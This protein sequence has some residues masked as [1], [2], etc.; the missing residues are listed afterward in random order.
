MNG[1]LVLENGSEYKGLSFG[2]EKYIS[3]EVVFSTNM[4]GYIESFTDPSFCDQI[5]C[6]TYPLIGNYGVP[7]ADVDNNN[8]LINMESANIWIKAL[9]VA[10]YSK[11][12]SHYNAKKSLSEWLIENKIPALTNIDTRRLTKELRLNG[13]LKG[14][15]IFENNEQHDQND[16]VDINKSNLVKKVTCKNLYT[17]GEGILHIAVLDCGIKL[18]ILRNLISEGFKITVLPYDY[19][20]ISENGYDGIFISNGPGDP[21]MCDITINN[22]RK[23]INSDN[24]KPVFGICLGNQLLAHAAGAKTYKMKY[25]NR[26]YNQPV[27]ML[28]TKT[29][30]ITSQNH[31]FAVDKDSLPEDWEELCINKNDN[32]N[33]GIRHKTK[34]FKSVQ[35]HPEARGGPFDTSYMF[36]EFYNTCLDHKYGIVQKN[37]VLL[38]GSGGLSIG[39]AGEFDYSGSQAIKSFKKNGLSVILVNP[40]IASIQTS[41]GL[42]DEVYYVP[43]QLEFITDIIIKERPQYISLS[44]G[45]QT[46]LN[47][48]IELFHS[49]ILYKY[50]V[51]VLGT[52]VDNILKTEDRDLFAREMHLIGEKTPRSLPGTTVQ[53][54]LDAAEEI[55]YPILCRAAFALGGL[56]SGFCDNKEELE[57]LLEKTFTKTKQVLIDEDLRGWKEIEY[58]VMRDK[59]GNSITIC[60]MENFDPLGIHTGDSIVVAP[61]QTLN[62]DEYNM[63]RSASLKIAGSLG[64]IG[65]CNVQMTLD[66]NSNEYRIIEVNPRLSRSSAL[67]SKATGY[68]IAAVAAQL[69]M[70]QRLYEITNVVTGTTTANFEPSLDYIV[71][72]IPRWDTRKFNGVDPRL[73]SA[74]KSVGEIMSIG[75]TFEE[76]FQK[77]LRMV[78]GIGFEP[79][80][81]EPSLDEIKIELKHPTDD[82]VR[83]LAHILYKNILSIDK[84]HKYSN[85]DKWFLHKLNNI[86]NI[87]TSPLTINL[88]NNFSIEQLKLLKLN[89]FSDCQI[90]RVLEV[91]E[92]IIRKMRKDNNINISV[93]KIDTLAGEFPADTNYLYTTYNGEVDDIEPC[94]DKKTIIVLGSG[95]YRIGSSVE[96]D[97]C[98]VKC[99]HTLRELGYHTIMINYNPET[100]STDFDESDKLYFD[101]ISFEKVADIY[102]KEKAYGVIVSMGGQEP[103]NIALKLHNYG[104]NVLGTSP[105]SIDNCEDRFKY[106]CLLDEL[107]IIQ[108][109]WIVANNKEEINIFIQEVGYP[110]II[111]PSYV[112]SGAA[113][114]IIYDNESLDTCINDASDIS[115][116]HP[117]VLTKFINEA[118]EVDLDAVCN[119]GKLVTYAISEHVENAGVHSGDAT[120][121]LPAHTISKEMQNRLLEV[122]KTIG[123]RLNVSGLFNTQFLVKGGWFGVIET[124][125]RASRSIPFVSKTLDIDFIKLATISMVEDEELEF[126]HREIDHVGVKCPQFSFARLPEADPILGV[127]MAST[128]EVACFGQTLDEAYLK[129]L[130]ASRSGVPIKNNLNILKLDNTD[131]TIYEKQGHNVITEVK[132]WK[133]IDMVIDCSNSPEN[134]NLRR[135]AVDFSKYVITNAQQV[136][137]LGKSLNANMSCNPY[138]FYKQ[139]IYK[140]RNIKIFIRQGFT[141]S[142]VE[143]QEK[144]QH[145]F[146]SLLNFQTDDTKFTL[147]TGNKA[148][149]KDTFKTNF[150]IENNREF[151]PENFRDYRLNKLHEADAMVILR[152]SLSESTVFEVAYNILQGPNIPVFFAIDPEAPLKTTLLRELDGYQNAT[153]VYKTMDHGIENITKDIDFLNFVN[154]L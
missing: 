65:E 19:D 62:N 77:G 130:I 117:V 107:K 147:V 82:R 128:G 63:L 9:V 21:S 52:S 44:F 109:A 39:Q 5:L 15:I 131:T 95:T 94:I 17:L 68:P 3:G 118:R 129:A 122:V 108:P 91:D 18:N 35:F 127:E 81:T 42:A 58:E 126:I 57:N 74:M 53:E 152:T 38:L 7:S 104:I 71:V 145:A 73:G 36:K 75:R 51:S 46:A 120:L 66:P 153:V 138:S 105:P 92:L 141:E 113:M 12:Y 135:N 6:L 37:K 45:G 151:N 103:N 83:V 34:P 56:G 89:G 22:L 20:F 136:E 154:N 61:S 144:L 32:S 134:R 121:V 88:S 67:A 64:I 13:S 106:S 150:E 148:E 123:L 149:S 102:E 137:L 146:N 2:Y 110:V 43:V 60:N 69:C 47:C 100:I 133:N 1:K 40:N 139:N 30:Y 101:E 125:L 11:H 10:E 96:F 28:E 115:P 124:N 112:L 140:T 4:S 114:R 70:G 26:G 33:E 119:N 55:G 84:I 29:T 90:G 99:M 31:G 78:R 54:A 50:N 23:Y 93:K 49:G 14:K 25:G 97:Y 24:Y 79:F 142:S 27:L 98:S 59:Y 85:I 48:G 86:K 132:N 87:I 80:G 76:A 8:L 41:E 143:K 72:K 116:D 16:F 111:R